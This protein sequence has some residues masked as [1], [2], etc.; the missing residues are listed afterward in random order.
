MLASIQIAQHQGRA[1]ATFRR[2]T[3]FFESGIRMNGL[4]YLATLD[5]LVASRGGIPLIADGK[6]IGGV[7]CSGGADSQ[8]EVVCRAGAAAIK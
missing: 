8:D 4:N 2:E 1:A 5:G 3:D 6:I 7:G